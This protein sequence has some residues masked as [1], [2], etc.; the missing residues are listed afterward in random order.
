M[1]ASMVEEGEQA[2]FAQEVSREEGR[3]P[4]RCK[5]IVQQDRLMNRL[6]NA[7][8]LIGDGL[9]YPHA[10]TQEPSP[11][12]ILLKAALLH[13]NEHARSHKSKQLIQHC[14]FRRLG[15]MHEDSGCMIQAF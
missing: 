11:D 3:L 12:S 5:G 7:S 14:P 1:Q 13:V 9:L 10:C 6:Q 4:R 2:V 8:Q 15:S